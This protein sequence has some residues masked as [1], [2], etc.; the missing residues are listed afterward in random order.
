MKKVLI[1][2]M[3]MVCLLSFCSCKD[4]NAREREILQQQID[5]ARENLDM[6]DDVQKQQDKVKDLLDQLG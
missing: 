4:K 2:L 1:A 3:A 5:Q 6:I